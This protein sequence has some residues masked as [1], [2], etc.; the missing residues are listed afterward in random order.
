MDRFAIGACCAPVTRCAATGEPGPI[1]GGS[2]RVN[3]KAPGR[4]Q[5]A[6]LRAALA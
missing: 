4:A 6:M 2:A 5:P 3:A 1:V